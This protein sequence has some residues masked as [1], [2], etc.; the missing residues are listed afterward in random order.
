MK[1]LILSKLLLYNLLYFNKAVFESYKNLFK[2]V[3]MESVGK[4]NVL[5]A[6]WSSVGR[7]AEKSETCSLLLRFSRNW[8]S[9]ETSNLF[10]TIYL[11]KATLAKPELLTTTTWKC[12]LEEAQQEIKL[13]PWFHNVLCCS[14]RKSKGYYKCWSVL[15]GGCQCE[16]GVWLL[17]GG[18]VYAQIWFIYLQ[19]LSYLVSVP[20]QIQPK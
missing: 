6:V 18:L 15:C 4:P 11:I 17:H 19:L 13:L 1:L 3:A 14:H 2:N 5:P 16:V 10:L 7:L 20:L 12:L 8:A 9:D